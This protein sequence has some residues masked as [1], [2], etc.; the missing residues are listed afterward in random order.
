MK[1][2]DVV[3]GE[4]YAVA[5]SIRK[6]RPTEWICCTVVGTGAPRDRAVSRQTYFPVLLSDGT[7]ST[8]GTRDIRKTWAEHKAD[9]QREV[10]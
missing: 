6:D 9:E 10:H 4:T 7:L 8:V 2:Q 5:Y 1:P 3:V